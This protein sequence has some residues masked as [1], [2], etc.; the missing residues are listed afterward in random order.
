MEPAHDTARSPDR[1]RDDASNILLLEHVNLQIADQQLA[2]LFYVV[3]LQLTRDPYLMVGLDN[4]WINVGRMQ[5]HLPTHASAPQRL[6]GIIGLIV[7]DLDA[8]EHALAAVAPQLG[9]TRFS[10]RREG[11]FVEATCP[12]GNRFRF[13][14]PDDVRWDSVQ[15]GL[16]YID[17]DVPAGCARA[18]AN[19]YTEMFGAHGAIDVNDEGLQTAAVRIG[20]NQRLNFVERHAPMPVY[21]GHHIQIYVAD[22]SRPHRRLQARNL[23]SKDADAHEWRFIDIVDLNSGTVVYQLEHEV[24]STRHPLFGRAFVNRNPAQTNRAYVRGQ[25]AFRGEY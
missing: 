5:F 21:D 10:F 4:M 12:W 11:R 9:G 23:L 6:R 2:T 16:M 18:I 17:L 20:T 22:F 14:A 1:R 8:L 3:G 25:D 19:F 7:P 13:H 24:R 15:L